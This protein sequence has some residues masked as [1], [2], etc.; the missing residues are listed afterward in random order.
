MFKTIHEC[1]VELKAYTMED[2]RMLG[3]ERDARYLPVSAARA[4]FIA[5]DKTGENT[6]KDDKLMKSLADRRHVGCFEHNYATM[7]VECPLF[8]ARQIMRHRSFTF[9]E[10][11]RRYTSEKLEFWIP[12]KLRKQ[13]KSN[14]QGSLDAEVNYTALTWK[15]VANEAIDVY[16]EVLS[17]GVCRE[18]A[19]AL[20]PQ[21]MLTRF[22][23]TGNI[24]SWWSFLSSRLKDDTQYETR[25]IAQKMKDHLDSLWPEAMGV[26]FPQKD[27]QSEDTAS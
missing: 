1:G 17:K 8:V 5:D 24:R 2:W 13:S 10:T 26:L 3:E 20:L 18:Q 21:S 11:S 12:D 19:R 9:N 25:V 7:V 15:I 14:K 27:E 4:S 16:N 22:Y 23:M 6:A